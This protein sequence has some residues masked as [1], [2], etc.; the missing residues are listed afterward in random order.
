MTLIIFVLNG[1]SRWWMKF[2]FSTDKTRKADNY[3]DSYQALDNGS[4]STGST[5]TNTEPIDRTSNNSTPT[6]SD[7][8]RS[9]SPPS[10]PRMSADSGRPLPTNNLPLVQDHFSKPTVDSNQVKNLSKFLFLDSKRRIFSLLRIQF[11]SWNQP[12]ESKRNFD[13]TLFDRKI[14]CFPE[15]LKFHRQVRSVRRRENEK[16]ERLNK[17]RLWTTNRELKNRVEIF[18]VLLLKWKK[19]AGSNF[20][21]NLFDFS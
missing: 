5:P 17:F 3:G 10:A 7:R 18:C 12:A 15:G 6:V 16:T 21:E 8:R 11:R 9:L 4:P 1:S 14:V 2:A 13:E 19:I 20:H